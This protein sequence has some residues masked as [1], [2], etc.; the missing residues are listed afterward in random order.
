M[1]RSKP[2][3]MLLTSSSGAQ[4]D[5]LSRMA[6]WNP[7]HHGRTSKSPFGLRPWTGANR[8]G[9]VERTTLISL[10]RS[11][12]AE[13]A[14]N[15]GVPPWLN[16][17]ASMASS[18]QI[19]FSDQLKASNRFAAKPWADVRETNPAQLGIFDLGTDQRDHESDGR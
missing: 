10:W 2:W 5:S 8:C 11:A 13:I 9:A 3:C 16:A 17:S 19:Q 1:G 18:G 6:A 7:W 15:S 12:T 4:A 14:A